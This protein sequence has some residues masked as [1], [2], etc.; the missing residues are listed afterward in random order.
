M[1]VVVE[2]ADAVVADLNAGSFGQPFT[3][4]R[5]YLPVFELDDIKNLRVTVVPKAVAIQATGRNSNQHDVAID[6]AVQKKLTKTGTAGTGSAG[7]DPTEIDPL[8]ALVEELADHFRFKRFTSPDA[9]WIRT[10]NEPVFAPEH[11]DQF[12]V[13]TSLL[14]LTFRVIR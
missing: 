2:I 12:R 8:M 7:I 4:E 9:V 6:V 14:T 13:F 10:Q 3:A 5:H 11:L 1:S